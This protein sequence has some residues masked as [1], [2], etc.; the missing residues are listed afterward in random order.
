MVEKDTGRSRGFGF[1]SYDCSESAALAIKELNGFVIGNKRLKVQHKQI[2]DTLSMSQSSYNNSNN[3]HSKKQH[4]LESVSENTPTSSKQQNRNWYNPNH[5]NPQTTFIPQEDTME[6]KEILKN[7][8]NHPNSN[9]LAEDAYVL[10]NEAVQELE[11]G[12][13]TQVQVG[14]ST[15]EDL[16][17]L[18]S[19]LPDLSD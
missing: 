4:T 11:D 10:S 18:K 6:Q 16:T 3:N 7:V 2:K 1:V 17:S 5:P 12:A 15:L 8:G 9:V 13:A 19:A 14:G